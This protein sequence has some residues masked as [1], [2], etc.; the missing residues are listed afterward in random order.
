MS[1]GEGDPESLRHQLISKM[2]A[3][4]LHSLDCDDWASKSPSAGLTSYFHN[5][6]ATFKILL[7]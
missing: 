6:Q 3:P 7:N 1:E 5:N 2:D 4:H